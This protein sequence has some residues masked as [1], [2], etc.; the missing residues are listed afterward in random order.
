VSRPTATKMANIWKKFSSPQYRRAF[1]ESQLSL[2]V[3]AQIQ[4]MREERG[5]TQA[6]LA[7]ATSMTQSRIS[8]LEDPAY[9]RMSIRTLSRIAEA[10]DVVLSV[11]FIPFSDLLK[12]CV[13]DD[14]SRYSVASFEDDR[15]P[16]DG[17]VYSVN[18][19]HF[20]AV[21]FSDY[22]TV[23]KIAGWANP[24]NGNK[25]AAPKGTAPI[26]GVTANV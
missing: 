5:W 4:T 14:S 17:L 24:E 25:M 11:R 15:Q 22:G 23:A 10:F 26:L 7:D 21:A 2:N 12:G 19:R 3:S 6:A 9:N 16:E 20:S 1:A 13:N 18:H 8:M